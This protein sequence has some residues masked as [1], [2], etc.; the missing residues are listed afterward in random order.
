MCMPEA[1]SQA[2]C[3]LVDNCN[4]LRSFSCKCRAFF[5]FRWHWPDLDQGHRGLASCWQ[6]V[7]YLPS[8]RASRSRQARLT[9][10]CTSLS[11]RVRMAM[12]VCRYTSQHRQS[13]L[14]LPST[15]T[16]QRAQLI[17]PLCRRL[18]DCVKGVNRVRP[19]LRGSDWWQ[20]SL[21]LRLSSAAFRS[22]YVLMIHKSETCMML[23]VR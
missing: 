14:T 20:L 19:S 18:S 13:I 17:S 22:I 9:H 6:T 2:W 10:S 12:Q 5:I 8:L 4:N 16:A 3:F 11:H 15:F 23:N 7:Q 21:V 1:L